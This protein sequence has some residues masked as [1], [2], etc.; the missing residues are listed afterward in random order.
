M[1]NAGVDELARAVEGLGG[2][3]GVDDRPSGWPRVV[4]SGNAAVPLTALAVV[5]GALPRYRLNV[6][7]APRGI[8]ARQG[9]AHETS[10]VGVGMRRLP[11]LAYVP[12]RLSMVPG[13]WAR[14][15]PPALVVL[16]TTAP[17]GGRVSLGIEV[18]VL[19]AA[20]EQVRA[21]GGLVV[22]Q[23]NPRMPYT[24]GDGELDADLVDLA[25]EV[26]EALPVHAASTPDEA[27]CLIGE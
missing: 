24:F 7:N 4:A 3:G 9:V 20:I 26:D 2:A 5:D 10:F 25:L 1:R 6:L 14:M 13:L 17:R 23:V 19:P 12:S 16:H 8:P 21:R 27:A 18:N 15:L 22:V 11:A